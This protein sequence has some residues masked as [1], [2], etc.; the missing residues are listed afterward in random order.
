MRKNEFEG[1]KRHLR[2]ED[3]RLLASRSPFYQ[4][5]RMLARYHARMNAVL[6]PSGIDMARWRVLNLLAERDVITVSE[7]AEESVVHI[8]TMAK[9][10]TRMVGEGFVTVRTSRTDARATEVTI[11]P[12]GLKLLEQSREKVNRV[13]KEAL[14]GLSK[15]EVQFLNSLSARIFENMAP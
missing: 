3:S 10:I 11:A 9:T 6:K 4:T 12:A 1:I 8:S 14:Q 5:V 7:I 2:S 13:F 15:S